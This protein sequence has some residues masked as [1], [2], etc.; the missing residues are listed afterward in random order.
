MGFLGFFFFK[1]QGGFGVGSPILG[2]S[3]SQGFPLFFFC[4]FSFSV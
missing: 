2:L 3:R 4:P 1:F